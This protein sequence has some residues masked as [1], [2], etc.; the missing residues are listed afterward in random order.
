MNTCYIF[1]AGEGLPKNFSPDIGDIVIAADAGIKNLS[2]FGISPDIAVG[3][4][5]S[6]GYVPDNCETIRHPVMKDDTDT[7]LALKTGLARGFQRFVIYGG[8]GG[9][10]DH[11]LANYQTLCF[12]ATHGAQ[13]YLC[14]DDY[15][16]CAVT[17]GRITFKSSA[18]G[19]IS[20]FAFCHCK[21][22]T[23]K[24]FLYSLEN[25]DL[26]PFFPLG[27]SN[28]FKGKESSVEVKNGTLVVI[29]QG[30]TND[31]EYLNSQS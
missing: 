31:V 10:P 28:S 21:G 26:S 15:C 9:R 30:C 8:T 25:S 24:G 7:M 6:L 11:T 13:A 17:D 29:W 12:A 18:S 14:E 2:V 19:N 1:G 27:A 5:D 3:D 23:L 20:V 22:V 4:F 16:A